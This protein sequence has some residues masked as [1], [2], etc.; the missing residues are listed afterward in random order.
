MLNETHIRNNN[1]INY[2]SETGF[3]SFLPF[4]GFSNKEWKNERR[5]YKFLTFVSE[6]YA[7]LFRKIQLYTAFEILK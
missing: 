6:N 4:E 2:K 1:V 3:T 5:V 7:D